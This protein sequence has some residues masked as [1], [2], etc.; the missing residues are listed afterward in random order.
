[1]S[2]AAGSSSK[3]K[4]TLFKHV[5]GAEKSK[6]KRNKKIKIEKKYHFDLTTFDDGV[7]VDLLRFLFTDKRNHLMNFKDN[8]KVCMYVFVC[9]SN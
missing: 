3:L 6:R 8:K 1:M 7:S 5:D 9:I 2:K 4:R